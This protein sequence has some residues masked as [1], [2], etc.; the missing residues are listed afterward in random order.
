MTNT[1]AKKFLAAKLECKE[2]YTSTSSCDDECEECSLCYAQGNMGEQKEALR[3]AIKALEQEPCEDCISRQAILNLKQTFYDEAGYETD[4]VDIEDIES[5][6]SVQPKA[7][8]KP[9]TDTRKKQQTSG[10][11]RT[12][13]DAFRTYRHIENKFNEPFRWVGVDSTSLAEIM[14]LA[15][16]NGYTYKLEWFDEPNDFGIVIHKRA[17]VF[18]YHTRQKARAND[19]ER[20]NRNS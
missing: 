5:L 14:E 15:E 20:S 18:I 19:T 4:Y 16:N 3:V 1:E 2:R 12:Y 9:K 13:D 17:M 11:I 10:S 8:Q 7:E 6:P